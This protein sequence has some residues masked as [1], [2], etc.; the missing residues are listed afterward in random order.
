MPT[1]PDAI[2][3]LSTTESAF[4]RPE[5]AQMQTRASDR[6]IAGL[7]ERQHGVV[8]RWQLLALGL[9]REQIAGRIT[10]GSLHRLH[11]G[12]YAVGYRVVSRKGRWMAAV[13][14]GGDDTVLSHRSA[15]ALW[16]IAT[17]RGAVEIT[18]PRDTRSRKE[19]RRH[20]ARLPVDEITVRDGIPVT[21]VHRTLFD[22]AGI[23]SVDRLEAAMREAEY[24]RLWDRLSLP[25]LLARHPGHRGN[26]KLRIC[27]D[28][29]GGTA[30]FTRSDLEELFLAALDRFG[31]PRPHLNARLQVGSEWIE[32]DCLWRE[33]RLIVELDGRAA[34]E[35][36]SAFEIDRDR[37]RR[38]QAKGWR[39]VRV[40]W[41]QLHDEP[42]RIAADLRSLLEQYKRM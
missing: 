17:F 9:G 7:A 39:V 16:G 12:V 10:R 25:A 37:D 11:V 42:E 3:G 23:S 21:S 5:D 26:A 38:L 28:R 4:V 14:V 35:T 6:G 18:S 31:L 30:G 29:L 8:A 34:H 41:R 2:V 20:V 15:A 40:T 24:R 33:E 1:G 19:L 13:L 27:L 32:V 22:F 36:R